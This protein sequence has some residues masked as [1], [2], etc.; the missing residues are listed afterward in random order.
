MCLLR[1]RGATPPPGL[2]TVMRLSWRGPRRLWAGEVSAQAVAGEGARALE[3]SGVVRLGVGDIDLAAH[4]IDDHRVQD[5]ADAGEDA[6]RSLDLPRRV[7]G[8]VDHEHVLV[9]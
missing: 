8:G 1:W 3:P 2:S 9:G 7:R 6:A 5:G 4:R